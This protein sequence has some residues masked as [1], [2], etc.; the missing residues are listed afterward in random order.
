MRLHIANDRFFATVS[1]A[2]GRF[3][4]YIFKSR[5]H[6]ANSLPTDA[7]NSCNR[8]DLV[9]HRGKLAR[10]LVGLGF[11]WGRLWRCFFVPLC[12]L[13]LGVLFGGVYLVACLVFVAFWRVL[14]L[15]GVCACVCVRLA[16]L[17]L[18]S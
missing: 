17:F 8:F 13:F 2:N 16:L 4:A 11:S 12:V 3:V 7:V 5:L 18:G 9:S 15:V 10:L 14:A 1:K 6:I